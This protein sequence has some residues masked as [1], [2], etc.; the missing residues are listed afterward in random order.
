MAHM[1]RILV[2]GGGGL[3]GTHLVPMLRS[4]ADV[5]APARQELDLSRPINSAQLPGSLDGV[6]YLAQSRRF[7]DFPA[8]VDDIFTVNVAN[9]LTLADHA[10]RAGAS[11]FIYASTGGVYAPSIAPLDE[12]SPLVDPMDFY[13]ASKYAAERLLL[14]F[15]AHM[16]VVILRFF[17]IYGRGQGQGMLIPRLIESVRYGREIALSGE[18]GLRINPIHV[19]DAAHVTAAA[20]GLSD[21]MTI[22]VAGSETISLRTIGEAIGREV[23]K[24]PRFA[25]TDQ[26]PSDLISAIDTMTKLLWAPRT[27]FAEG[28]AGIVS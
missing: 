12:G 26:P 28:L 11:H 25:I 2:T 10:R 1:T 27:G 17:F 15:A 16:T 9:P 14:P 5:V 4:S 22:N 13:P 21:S 8:A 24:A 20:L 6:I 18:L 19:T 7:R 23:G 3:L